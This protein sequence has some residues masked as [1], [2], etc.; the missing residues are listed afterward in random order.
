MMSAFYSNFLFLLK[1]APFIWRKMVS[2]TIKKVSLTIK[3]ANNT[4]KKVSLAIKKVWL[5]FLMVNAAIKK[6]AE[7][8]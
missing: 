4:I 2:R 5:T 6:A 7:K 1:A 8:P 3:K